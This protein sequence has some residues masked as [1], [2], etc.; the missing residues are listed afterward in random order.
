MASQKPLVII[1][2]Q[3]Q[4]LPAGDTLNASINEVDVLAVSNANASSITVGQP[5]YVSSAGAVNLASAAASGT[6]KVLGLVRSASIASSSSGY[7]QTD[8]VLMADTTDWDAVTGGTGGLTA[9]SVYYL[10]STAGML[11]TTAPGGSGN[12][13][14]KVGMAV[15]TTELEIDTDRGGVLLA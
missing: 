15:S 9:G 1:N 2:G 8:G 5:V 12:F 7:V 11:T 13:V 3:V 14:M 4:Q 6:C 10:S